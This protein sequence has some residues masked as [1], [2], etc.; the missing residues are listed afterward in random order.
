MIVKTPILRERVRKVPKSFSWIDHRLVRDGH[1]ESCSHAAGFLYLF[2]VCVSDDKGLSYY[3][4]HTLMKKLSMEETAFEKAR[5]ELV[6]MGL[7]AWQAP[8]YQVLSLEPSE[9][10]RLNGTSM[11]LGDILKSAMEA[12]HD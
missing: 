2:L 10:A 1:I 12:A 3:G 4:D 9:K 7:L 11:I 5:S 6:R 8:L